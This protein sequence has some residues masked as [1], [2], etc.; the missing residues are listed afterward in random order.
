MGGRYFL[1][2]YRSMDV[3]CRNL[4]ETLLAMIALEEQTRLPLTAMVPTNSVFVCVAIFWSRFCSVPLVMLWEKEFWQCGQYQAPI[5][6]NFLPIC[7]RNA[8]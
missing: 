8:V 6:A 3:G 4:L 2:R 1:E 7:G 5:R